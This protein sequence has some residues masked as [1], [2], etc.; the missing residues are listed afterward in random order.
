VPDKTTFRVPVDDEH[1]PTLMEQAVAAGVDPPA[2][3][4]VI[5]ND[6]LA[7]AKRQGIQLV[8]RIEPK[9]TKH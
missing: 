8:P 7:F 5:V 1:M 2:L 6:I 4:D 9:Q 3:L